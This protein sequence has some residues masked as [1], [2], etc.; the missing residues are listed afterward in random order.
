MSSIKCVLKS[1]DLI[2]EYDVVIVPTSATGHLAEKGRIRGYCLFNDLA[3]LIERLK[4]DWKKV[5]AF[6]SDAHHGVVGGIYW[7]LKQ[8]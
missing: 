1:A 3:I 5:A 4:E 6:E 8:I 7:G 2:R